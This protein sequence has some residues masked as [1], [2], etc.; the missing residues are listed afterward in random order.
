MLFR[1][2]NCHTH[3]VKEGTFE[4]LCDLDKRAWTLTQKTVDV[5]A[6]RCQVTI[7]VPYLP[8]ENFDGY[9]YIARNI[10]TDADLV[11]LYLSSEDL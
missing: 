4:E 1:A 7:A 11:G 5:K 9:H 3:E 6:P 8:F 10:Y 2:V